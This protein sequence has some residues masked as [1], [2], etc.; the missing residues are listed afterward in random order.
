MAKLNEG[1]HFPTVDVALAV[2][3]LRLDSRPETRHLLP[4]VKA[5]NDEMQ[6]AHTAWRVAVILAMAATLDVNYRDELV[7]AA[8]MAISR[9]LLAMVGGNRQALLWRQ[10]Y[11]EAPSKTV[12]PMATPEQSRAVERVIETI[13][14]DDAYQGLRH[15]V[16][17]LVE[18]QAD[19]KTALVAREAADAKVHSAAHK[20]ELAVG[21]ARQAY[22]R[23]FPE[24]DLLFPN[25]PARVRYI[26]G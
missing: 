18:A 6:A 16:P 20:R 11:S 1:D 3:L 21:A 13:T 4:P 25:E 17:A 22:N 24:L 23:L 19:L 10:V 15:L 14:A 7:D 2:V 5:A 26:L 8:Y 9:A 12:A